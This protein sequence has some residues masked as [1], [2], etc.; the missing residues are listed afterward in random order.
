MDCPS[1]ICIANTD[2]ANGSYDL[3]YEMCYINMADIN[4]ESWLT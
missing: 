3:L 4:M 2:G 1:Q